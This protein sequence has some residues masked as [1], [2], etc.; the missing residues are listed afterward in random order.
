MLA[1]TVELVKASLDSR[2]V[3]HQVIAHNIANAN[4]ADY[5]PYQISFD[6]RLDRLRATIKN[7]DSIEA[8]ALSALMPRVERNLSNQ[9]FNPKIALDLEAA[10]L[11][12]NVL[13]YQ[14]VIRAYSQM[15]TLLGIAV[16]EGK[17]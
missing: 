13:Q 2:I 15:T 11:G 6:G 14:A 1:S 3:Q 7:G 9:G 4:T 8:S 16:S 10:K 5:V 12:G 17:R